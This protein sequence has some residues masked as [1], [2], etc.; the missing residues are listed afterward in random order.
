MQLKAH[1]RFALEFS[2]RLLE[3][4]LSELE[5]SDWFYQAHEKSNYPLWVV[6][7]LGLADNMFINRFRPE[8]VKKPE[9]WDALFWFGS[10]MLPSTAYPP[11]DE[12]L[13]YFRER[14][15]ALL[16]L[17]EEL[18]DAELDAPAPAPGERSPIA[19]APSIGQLF[20]FASQHESLHAGQLTI[21]HRA[22]G[23]APLIGRPASK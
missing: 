13:A 9:G 1:A 4:I 19:G 14:R 20:L 6:G 16:Q 18:T 23:K 7:H 11:V 10:Q 5:G 15:Q 22:V 8:R 3:G 2:R 21:A 17:L 12:V